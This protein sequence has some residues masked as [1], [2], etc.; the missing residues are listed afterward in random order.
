MTEFVKCITLKS[1]ETFGTMLKQNRLK[2]RDLKMK[3]FKLNI[4]RM[5]QQIYCYRILP[6]K[7]LK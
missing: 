4:M 6:D 5:S 7:V 3:E 1:C 2:I